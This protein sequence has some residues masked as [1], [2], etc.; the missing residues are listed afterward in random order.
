MSEFW[1]LVSATDSVVASADGLTEEAA[2]RL[3]ERAHEGQTD[4]LGE[5]YIGH[6]IRVAARVRT[7]DEKVVALLHDV[8]EDTDL[9]IADLQDAGASEGQ[10]SALQAL[11]HGE[12]ESQVAYCDRVAANEL[13]RLVKFADI[14]DNSDP[15]R[16]RLLHPEMRRR[17]ELKYKRSSALLGWDYQSW[18]GNDALLRS[19]HLGG[20]SRRREVLRFRKGTGW[21]PATRYA[22]DALTGMGEDLWSCGEYAT[23]VSR[24][25]AELEAAAAGWTLFGPDGEPSR[26]G[27]DG[28]S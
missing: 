13:A 4:K 1:N 12:D 2:L 8:L 19:S 10:L 26:K 9:T 23:P 14:A 25:V 28:G 24:L 21:E 17:L 16:L 3:A 6:P 20:P 11:C 15:S 22:L 5:P 18:V 7:R 27:E